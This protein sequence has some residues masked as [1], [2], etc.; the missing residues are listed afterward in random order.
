MAAAS[1]STR[2]SSAPPARTSPP[3]APMVSCPADDRVDVFESDTFPARTVRRRWTIY[4]AWSACGDMS[5]QTRGWRHAG[6]PSR[7]PAICGADSAGDEAAQGATDLDTHP[8]VAGVA[9]IDGDQLGIR[10]CPGQLPGDPERTAHVGCAV[11]GGC[12]TNADRQCG[13]GEG[14]TCG[15]WPG[16]RRSSESRRDGVVTEVSVGPISRWRPAPCSPFSLSSAV[17]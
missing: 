12:L 15:T 10:P 7:R 13:A 14:S 4:S 9:R 6:T 3:Q 16:R 5:H 11:R 8:I 1:R 17:A 2:W